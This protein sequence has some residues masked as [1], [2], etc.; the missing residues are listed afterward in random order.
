M[1]PRRTTDREVIAGRYRLDEM[2]GSGGA[3]R[4]FRAR[5]EVSGRDVAIKLWSTELA[6]GNQAYERFVREAK[7]ASTLRHANLIEC[8]GFSAE[9]GYIVM[10]LMA[11]SLAD[12][13]SDA[14]TEKSV[15]RMA[16]DVLGGLELAHQRGIIH[17]DVKPANVFFDARGIAKLGDFG[18]AHLTDLGQTQTGG[19]IGT[20]A[21]M[22]P[23]Q[24][25]GARLTITADLYS[26]GVTVFE[27]LT[28]RPPFLGPDFVA[29]AP[30]RRTAAR[31]PGRRDYLRVGSNPCQASAQ[32]SDRAIRIDR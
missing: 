27:A 25:T 11:G 22:A 17:R 32:E 9:M 29:P 30:R 2:L 21:Y 28:G 5:D 26:L 12:R 13:V 18:V 31:Q 8:Y 7:V 3:G 1:A 14:M 20:L 16:L 6:R 23:E 19:L 10:E 24:I 4:V 15:R